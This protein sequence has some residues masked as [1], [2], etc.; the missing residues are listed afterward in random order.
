[1]E[2]ARDLLDLAR[3]AWSEGR[4]RGEVALGLALGAHAFWQLYLD[5]P[6]T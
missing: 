1:M 5:L 4:G 3:P 2:H 6:R